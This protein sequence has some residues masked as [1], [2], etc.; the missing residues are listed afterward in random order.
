MALPDK[1]KTDD[2]AFQEVFHAEMKKWVMPRRSV[3]P[4]RDR[5]KPVEPTLPD[6]GQYRPKVDNRLI[7]LALSGGGIRAATFSLG[8]LQRLGRLGVLQ[9][10]DLLSTAS[11][12]GYLGASWSSLTAP[13]RKPG[14][15]VTA[16][17]TPSPYGSGPDTFPFKFTDQE[18]HPGHQIFNRESPAV[19]HLRAHGNYLAPHLGLLDVWTWVA[20]IRYLFSTALLLVL[21]PLPWLLSLAGPSMLVPP[22]LWDRQDPWGSNIGFLNIGFFN[23]GFFMVAIP[24]AALG[25]FAVLAVVVSLS[26]GAAADPDA[27][28]KDSF[29]WAQKIALLVVV[30]GLLIDLFIGGVA[31]MYPLDEVDLWAALLAAAS[32]AGSVAGVFRFAGGAQRGGATARTGGIGRTALNLLLGFVGYVALGVLLVMGY[33]ALDSW[34]FS[35]VGVA[36]SITPTG[37]QWLF[38]IIVAAWGVAFGMLFMPVQGFL[39]RLSLQ[40]L[41]RR[42]L[43][44]AYLLRHLPSKEEDEAHPT[45]RRLVVPDGAD[46]LLLKDLKKGDA[47]PDMPYHLIGAALNT[48]GDS[49]PERLGRRSDSFVFAHLSSGSRITGY[50]STDDSAASKNISLERA[51]TISGAA[52]SPNMGKYTSAT[53]A[54]LLTLFNVRIGAWLPNPDKSKRGRAS[55]QPVICYWL[56]ELF[57]LASAEDRYVY[58]T[59]GGHFDNSGLYELLK[60]RCKYIIAV[61]ASTDA[62]SLENLATAARLARIDLGVQMDIDMTPL[63]PNPAAHP[64]GLARP[65][66]VGRIKYPPLK[67]DSEP[68]EGVLVFLTTV[69]APREKPDVLKYEEED[70]QFPDQSTADQFFDEAQFESYR[71]LG[72]T[73]VGIAFPGRLPPHPAGRDLTRHGLEAVFQEMLSRELKILEPEDLG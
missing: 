47:P 54:I 58:L 10:V 19:Q 24:L 12:G 56:K 22:S 41:Y 46:P 31:L 20:L 2:E 73:A 61:D 3:E 45:A 17:P 11:G 7:G 15:P 25:V 13:R 1:A 67:G 23:L 44:K 38:V 36:R 63:L 49:Q 52:L 51:M 65:Y 5:G 62:S 40:I 50:D 59:D 37:G 71:Q 53:L 28:H 16:S 60:R 42:G 6:D 27:E 69:L 43:S 34:L 32:L 33:Y 55:W 64:P 35:G 57:G 29:Y 4:P 39:N 30:A 68:T 14:E 26:R 21:L 48:S 66:A 70:P 8:A 18:E 9:F 72:H